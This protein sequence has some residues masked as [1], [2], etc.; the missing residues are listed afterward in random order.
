MNVFLLLDEFMKISRRVFSREPCGYVFFVLL[1][2]I[3][4]QHL[5]PMESIGLAYLPA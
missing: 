5:Y 3:L 4:V 1:W 2:F